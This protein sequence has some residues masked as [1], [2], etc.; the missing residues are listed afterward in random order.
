MSQ[1]CVPEFLE[2]HPPTDALVW[3]VLGEIEPATS[4]VIAEHTRRSRS[5]VDGA[6]RRLHETG[7]VEKRP[8][9]QDGRRTQYRRSISGQNLA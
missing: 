4:P 2:E 5:A 7:V 1:E 8:H 9:P 3:I 6:L